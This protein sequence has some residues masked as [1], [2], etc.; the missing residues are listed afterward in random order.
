MLPLEHSA[1][2]LEHS[3]ILLT[4]I[5]VIIGLENQFL[6]FFRVA[7][8][9]RFYCTLKEATQYALRKATDLNVASQ[10]FACVYNKGKTKPI[11]RHT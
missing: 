1:I 3:A 7:I 11:C 4:C 2:P 9:D 10:P 8:L 6:V 5:K